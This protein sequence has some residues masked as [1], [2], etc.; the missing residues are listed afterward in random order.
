MAF[1]S[2]SEFSE[3]RSSPSWEI[4]LSLI[5]LW[6]CAIISSDVA[7]EVSQTIRTNVIQ[8]IKM[9]GFVVIDKAAKLCM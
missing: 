5:E 4:F 9:E 7:D 6:F 2:W 1:Q 8:K 3:E